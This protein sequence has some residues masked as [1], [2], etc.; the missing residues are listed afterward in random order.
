[1]A[2]SQLRR[3]ERCREASWLVSGFWETSQPF[4]NQAH[5]MQVCAVIKCRQFQDM[6]LAESAAAGQ[7]IKSTSSLA[8]CLPC[9]GNV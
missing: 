9:Q 8:C 2:W 5:R 4:P 7:V 3:V 6:L 1:M